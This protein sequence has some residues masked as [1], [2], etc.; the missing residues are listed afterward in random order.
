MT[1]QELDSLM[2]RV[3][4]DAIRKDEEDAKEETDSFLPS[5]VYGQPFPAKAQSSCLTA[6]AAACSKTCE[7]QPST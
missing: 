2:R 3:L 6:N 1:D 4:M 5:R 7:L